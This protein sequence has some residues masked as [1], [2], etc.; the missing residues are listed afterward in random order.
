MPP[1][2]GGS[3]KAKPGAEKA[4]PGAKKPPPEFTS[5]QVNHFREVF[6]MFGMLRP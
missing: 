6:N 3:E 2:A 1:P 5:R 4:K